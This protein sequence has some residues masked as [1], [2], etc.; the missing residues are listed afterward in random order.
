MRA[1]IAITCPPELQSYVSK[2]QAKLKTLLPKVIPTKPENLHLTLKFLDQISCEESTNI[3]QIIRQIARKS[4]EFKIS[5]ETSGVFPDIK[6]ARVI[7]L[8][9]KQ[10]PEDLKKITGEL[11]EKLAALG[12]AREKRQFLIHLTI[13]RIKD[14]SDYSALEKALKQI[15]AELLKSNLE[16]IAEGIALFES[17]LE[18]SGPTYTVLE[19]ANFRIA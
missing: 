7:W 8:G 6:Q 12:I 1:F 5:F 2:I 16:F 4:S 18:R 14:S 11:E 9:S 13:G 10:T 15:N 17:R 19:E 3:K